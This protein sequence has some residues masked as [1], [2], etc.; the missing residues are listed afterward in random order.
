[1]PATSPASAPARMTVVG[2]VTERTRV[3]LSRAATAALVLAPALVITW[4]FRPGYMNADSI[5]EYA[6]TQPGARFTDWRAPLIEKLWDAFE[7]A[8]IGSPTIVLFAQTLTLTAGFYLVLRAVLG[9]VSAALLSAVLVLSPIVLSQVQL[10]ARDTW[11]ICFVV[12]QVGCAIRWSTTSGPWSRMWLALALLAGLLALATRQNGAIL[13]LFVLTGMAA[14]WYA[15]RN[16]DRTRLRGTAVPAVLG[17]AACILGFGL[18]TTLPRVMGAEDLEP[19]SFVYAYDLT[20]MSIRENE[21]LIGPE[22]FPSQDLEA[23]EAQ[24][25]PIAVESVVTP[26]GNALVDVVDSHRRAVE[27]LREAWRRE[28]RERPGA[29]LAVRWG[30]FQRIIGTSH[31]PTTVMHHGVDANGWGLEIENPEANDA[32]RDYVGYFSTGEDFSEGGWLFRPVVWIG[33]GLLAAAA[34]LLPPSNRARPGAL[35]CGLLAV[36]GVAFEA[37]YFFLAM[38]ESFRYSYPMVV[39]SLL[40]AVFFGATAGRARRS[41]STESDASTGPSDLRKA[42]EATWVREPAQPGDGSGLCTDRSADVRVP[43]GP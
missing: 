10:V 43:S 29:Y 31:P 37:G 40:A 35:E 7:T 21:V 27:E 25:Q 8:G 26:M 24:W 18:V 17:A 41:R 38:S 13:E 9:R 1:V 28:V 20:G 36:G 34:L 14:R 3:A 11:L 32:F 15:R 4:A 16:P 33:V 12:F 5:T 22:A 42:E 39:A 30:L 23:L 6:V 2:P 19:E